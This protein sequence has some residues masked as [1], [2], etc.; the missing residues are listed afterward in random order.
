MES[1]RRRCA[2]ATPFYRAF[3]ALRSP[4]RACAY[5]PRGLAHRRTPRSINVFFTLPRFLPCLAHAARCTAAALHA[6]RCA[7]I[8]PRIR[9]TSR[10]QTPLPRKRCAG[11]LL[12][13]RAPHCAAGIRS[14]LAPQADRTVDVAVSR[15]EHLTRC[16]APRAANYITYHRACH[17]STSL[18]RCAGRIFMRDSWHGGYRI[19]GRVTHCCHDL[20]PDPSRRVNVREQNMRPFCASDVGSVGSVSCL[21]PHRHM[22]DALPPRSARHFSTGAAR[23][24]PYA[25]APRAAAFILRAAV[26]GAAARGRAAQHNRCGCRFAQTLAQLCQPPLRARCTG[27]RSAC[28]LFAF[29]ATCARYCLLPFLRA[30]H[31]ATPAFIMS[32]SMNGDIERKSGDQRGGQN[33]WRQ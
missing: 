14:N 1:R 18:P 10:C 27:T 19:V 6:P 7:A 9:A 11:T 5:A 4:V 26:R 16:C 20:A 17:P 3:A 22:V 32:A 23:A 15:C 33:G 31:R 13:H 29:S 30:A 21:P 2:D 25:A 12:P 28:L 8:A 24:A